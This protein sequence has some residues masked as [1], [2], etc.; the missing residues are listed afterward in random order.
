MYPVV[1]AQVPSALTLSVLFAVA[2]LV[3]LELVFLVVDVLVVVGFV[4]VEDDLLE[5][6]EACTELDDE[7]EPQVPPTGL[8]PVPQYVDAEPQYP[9]WLQQFPNMEPMQ[10]MVVPHV[11]S[12]EMAWEAVEVLDEAVEEVLDVLEVVFAVVDVVTLVELEV[13]F[14]DEVDLIADEELL[15][16]VQFPE[17]GWHPAPQYLV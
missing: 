8:H 9:Y 16:D 17:A 1:P 12:V 15:V 13:V 5:L 11:P 10:V 6:D 3:V 4:E 7:L 14:V 2:L